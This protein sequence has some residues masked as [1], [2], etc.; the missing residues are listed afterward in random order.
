MLLHKCNTQATCNTPS[1]TEEVG[2]TNPPLTRRPHHEHPLNSPRTQ[3]FP[4]AACTPPHWI[5]C[6]CKIQNMHFSAPRGPSSERPRD[7]MNYRSHGTDP[8]SANRARPM[9]R[10]HSEDEPRISTPLHSPAAT[11]WGCPPPQSAPNDGPAPAFT[12]EGVRTQSNPSTTHSG[13]PPPP[14]AQTETKAAT[15]T[16]Q[17]PSPQTQQTVTGVAVGTPT[18]GCGH[19][20]PETNTDTPN[21]APSS[22]PLSLSLRT[23]CGTNLHW[24]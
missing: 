7:E 10:P 20:T 17:D 2:A 15:K 3:I 18:T 23:Y 5:L 22:H 12:F 24:P 6:S 13:R 19:E 14:R 11:G 4:H 1:K 16:L 9:K 8:H 21:P